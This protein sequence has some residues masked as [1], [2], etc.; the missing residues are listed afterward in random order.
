MC[1]SLISVLKLE[2]VVAGEDSGKMT[3]LCRFAETGIKDAFF[4]KCERKD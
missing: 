4:V 2:N 1:V 3:D